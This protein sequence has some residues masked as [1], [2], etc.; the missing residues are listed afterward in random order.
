M[1][2]SYELPNLETKRLLLTKLD[3][4]H[5]DDLFEVYSE[6]Q[7]TT[8]VPRNV[9][10]N[11]EETHSLLEKM[12]K[13]TKEGKAFVWSVMLQEN[14]KAI[15]TCGIW[16]LPHSNASLGA[17]ISPLYWGKGLIVEALEELIKFGFQELSL[18]RIEGRCDVKNIASE[19]VMQKLQMIY[20]GTLRQSVK[21][22]ERYCDSK[23]YSL[24]KQEYNIAW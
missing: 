16:I 11:K 7:T 3:M 10:E 8:Y 23:V 19:R 15:G 5:L 13:A 24:L 4:S 17:V 6:P 21:I 1:Q 9:H 18:N 22:N 14:Q 20:E 12:M 2:N